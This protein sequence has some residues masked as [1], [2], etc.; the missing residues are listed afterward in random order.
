M[1]LDLAGMLQGLVPE[2]K[3][4]QAKTYIKP[5]VA[6]RMLV[7]LGCRAYDGLISVSAETAPGLYDAL[8]T[9]G[10]RPAGAKKLIQ[11]AAPSQLPPEPEIRRNAVT[12]PAPERPEPTRKGSRARSLPRPV[13][14]PEVEDWESKQTEKARVAQRALTDRLTRPKFVPSESLLAAPAA[15]AKQLPPSAVKR[16]VE[17]LSKKKED[18][19]SQN[20]AAPAE[21]D[22]SEEENAEAARELARAQAEATAAAKAERIRDSVARLASAPSRPQRQQAAVEEDALGPLGLRRDG[23]ELVSAE[24]ADRRRISRARLAQLA[25]PRPTPPDPDEPPS[26]VRHAPAPRAY[27]LDR[28]DSLSKPKKRE[29]AQLES[30][31]PTRVVGAYAENLE[32]LV[33]PSVAKSVDVKGVPK[34]SAA[35]QEAAARRLSKK[36]QILREEEQEREAKALEREAEQLEAMLEAA[37]RPPIPPEA[38]ELV[39]VFEEVLWT[40]LTCVRQ[41][42]CSPELLATVVL[43]RPDR[44]VGSIPLVPSPCIVERLRQEFPA[45]LARIKGWKIPPNLDEGVTRLR[46][47]RDALLRW[48]MRPKPDKPRLARVDEEPATVSRWTDNLREVSTPRYDCQGLVGWHLSKGHAAR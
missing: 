18:E 3:P 10:F 41:H 17:R 1:E 46:A 38:Q 33:D 8:E 21:D 25:A 20:G 32:H 22:D 47:A 36:A 23:S 27:D 9:L 42:G 13:A 12:R 44:G 26:L 30:A 14:Y 7:Q 37:A 15:K 39:A 34:R 48:S 40:A 16:L 31:R 5:H 2:K 11:I 24:P 28:L 43:L 45:L 6:Y 29:Q 19:L 35:A 4:V